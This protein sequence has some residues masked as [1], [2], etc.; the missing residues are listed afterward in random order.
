MSELDPTE[1]EF[2]PMSSNVVHVDMNLVPTVGFGCVLWSLRTIWS[3]FELASRQYIIWSIHWTANSVKTGDLMVKQ[4]LTV[5]SNNSKTHKDNRSDPDAEMASW[6]PRGGVLAISGPFYDSIEKVCVLKVETCSWVFHN[7]G[8]NMKEF[9]WFDRFALC[10]SR[11]EK[12]PSGSPKMKF[13]VSAGFLWHGRRSLR[14]ESENLE[15]DF[16]QSPWKHKD[17]S[18]ILRVLTVGVMINWSRQSRWD[19]I[20][21]TWEPFR[22][23]FEVVLS[24][25]KKILYQ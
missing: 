7:N 1:I 2:W 12:W 4:L 21:G 16:P 22:N 25:K 19:R 11:W 18:L 8:W 17:I 24:T 20:H 15:L 5:L 23:G 6:S 10:L 9:R 3:R 13:W 14:A